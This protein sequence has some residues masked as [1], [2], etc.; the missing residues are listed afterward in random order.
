MELEEYRKELLEEIKAQASSNNDSIADSFITTICDKLID[1]EVL[2]SYE[3]CYI[4]YIG[5]HNKIGRINGYSFE[6][7]DKTLTIILSTF[8]N[9]DRIKTLTKTES[10]SLFGRGEFAFQNII[11]GELVN[12][13]DI[14]TPQYDFINFIYNKKETIQRVRYIIVTDLIKSSAIKSLDIKKVNN[15]NYEYTIWDIER[16]YKT[17]QSSQVKEALII[18][19]TKYVKQGIPL[20]YADSNSNTYKSY[21]GVIPGKLLADIYDTYGSGL[22]EG[23]V[24]SFLS[25]RGS[26]NKKIRESILKVPE[27]FFAYNNGIAATANDIE[28]QETDDGIRL[29]SAKDFQIVNG[30]QTTATLST[31][32]FKDKSSLENIYVQ[33][34]LTKIEDGKADEIIP[35]ISRSSNSQNKVSEVDFFSTSPFHIRIE[36]IA[37]RLYAPAINGNQFETHWFYERARGQYTQEQLKM[38]NAQKKKYMTQNPKKQLITKSDLAKYIN[39]WN[40]KPNIV[41]KGAQ[42]SFLEFATYIDPVWKENDTIFNEKYYKDAISLAILFKH[43]EKLVSN[44]LWYENAYRANIVTYSIALFRYKLKEQY[45][46]KIFDLSKIWSKQSVPKAISDIFVKITKLVFDS[47]TSPGKATMNVT[48]W[49]KKQIAW[50]EIKKIEFIMPVPIERFLMSKCEEKKDISESK[51][52]QK[53]INQ[54]EYQTKVVNLGEAY[55]NKVLKFGREKGLLSN[56]DKKLLDLVVRLRSNR[57]PNPFQCKLLFEL[58]K[59]LESEG[60]S[61]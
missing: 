32:R 61:I 57:I 13:Y 59:R 15:I 35:K 12:R 39:S 53:V 26:V 6:Q 36:Q 54:I 9:E 28:I 27:M 41:S 16:L 48:Q 25:I 45:K 37:R 18:D 58:E 52:E 29:L 49:C 33:M 30:G 11:N 19:F 4:D 23:N 14:S 55:W 44:Q 31:V 34:K 7:F 40:E 1:I 24:R 8:S 46:D 42:S 21:L 47:I 3:I 17:Y 2:D 60:L 56:E 10:N 51:K 5:K 22:L 50:D 20:L 38:T 43:V